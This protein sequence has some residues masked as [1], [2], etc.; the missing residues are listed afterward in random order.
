MYPDQFPKSRISHIV[1]AEQTIEI[2]AIAMDNAPT[3]STT[4]GGGAAD[5]FKQSQ[6]LNKKITKQL[7]AIFY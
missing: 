2:S 7:K 4:V 3:I 5:I 1:A 6:L